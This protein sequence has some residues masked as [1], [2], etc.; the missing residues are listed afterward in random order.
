M[1]KAWPFLCKLSCNKPVF[2]KK[3]VMLVLLAFMDHGECSQQA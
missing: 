1:A 2:M 3:L